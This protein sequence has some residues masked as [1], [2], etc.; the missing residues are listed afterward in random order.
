MKPL[1]ALRGFLE[2]HFPNTTREEMWCT[3][4]AANHVRFLFFLVDNRLAVAVVPEGARV[5]AGDMAEAINAKTVQPVA[6]N[7]LDAAFA[8]S[9]LGRTQPFDNP[10]GMHVFFDERL[11]ECDELVFCPRMF[12]GKEGECFRAPTQEFI[13]LVRPVVL[14]LS[15]LVYAHADDW[16][17]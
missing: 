6:V 7:D 9:E 16:A 5:D 14:P 11:R 1:A 3:C 12:F 15:T 8:E 10:F 13:E 4:G 2:Q 17:V